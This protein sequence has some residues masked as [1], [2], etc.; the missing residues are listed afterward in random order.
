MS[1][2][3]AN[4]MTFL[5]WLITQHR[6]S[7]NHIH[8]VKWSDRVCWHQIN[9]KWSL[10]MAP[11]LLFVLF[12]YVLSMSFRSRLVNSMIVDWGINLWNLTACFFCVNS[13]LWEV[14]CLCMCYCTFAVIQPVWLRLDIVSPVPI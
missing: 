10:G 7:T 14:N 6:R 5:L 4:L 1:K 9:L 8:I 13:F 3:I 12:L 11:A 2:A